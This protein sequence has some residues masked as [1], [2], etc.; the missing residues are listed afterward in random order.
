M[1]ICKELNWSGALDGG[2]QCWKLNIL[3]VTCN[4]YHV[5]NIRKNCDTM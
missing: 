1:Y 4:E 2:F 3:N 5:L